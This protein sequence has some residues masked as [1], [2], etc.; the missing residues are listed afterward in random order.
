MEVAESTAGG[1]KNPLDDC[2]ILV[3]DDEADFLDTLIKRLR[4]R[5][6]DVRSAASAQE[7]LAVLESDP[8]DVVVLDVRMPQMDGI[9]LL[10]IIKQRHAPIEVIM[11]T[12]HA[13]LEAAVKGMD[14]GAFDYLMK[15]VDLDE[16]IYKMQ[17][18]Y[19]KRLLQK[20]RMRHI[21]S[22]REGT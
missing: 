3:V 15:P 11:L 1:K 17:D 7:A 18:A 13:S 21:A 9:R 19:R 8:V 2:K 5:R 22:S 12:G 16:L 4:R 10:E 14:L 20:G 6:V